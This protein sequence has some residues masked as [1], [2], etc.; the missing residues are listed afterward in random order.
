M[1]SFISRVSKLGVEVV[2]FDMDGTL[3][4]EY[5]FIS[6]AYK[7]VSF[8]I[9]E[10]YGLEQID[11]YK[12]L[13]DNWKKFGSSANIFQKTMQD[14]S[15]APTEKLIKDCIEKYRAANFKL[16]MTDEMVYLL[17]QLKKIGYKLFLIT[18]G[19]EN[20]Q[21]RKIKELGLERWFDDEN[22]AISGKYGK[23]YQKPNTYMKD[24]IRVLNEVNKVLYVGDR[25]ID[26]AFAKN[27][28]F[29]FINVESVFGPVSEKHSFY[30]MTIKR[31]FDVIL[32]LLSIIILLP[33]FI[34]VVLLELIC[35]GRPIVYT[36][37]RPGK[38]GKIFKMY[39]F[40]SMTNEIGDD[41]WLL[42]EDQRLTKFGRFIRKT[43]IDE[44]PELFNI[45]K[46]D[47]S[48]V[49]PRP[50]L[51]EYM[52][53]YSDRHKGRHLV[54]PGL[55]C[56]RIIPTESKTW[57]WGEQ[58]N[59]DLWYVKNVSFLVDVKMILAVIKEVFKARDIRTNDDRPPFL[60]DNLYDIRNKH[61]MDI[62]VRHE[63]IGR[64][65]NENSSDSTT[66]RR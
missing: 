53:Y 41:G 2:G 61:E 26:A 45:L 16:I 52:D 24:R 44:L 8:C 20:L 1:K 66:S 14:F 18:D 58:F 50:L 5:D 57:T 10:Y 27:C 55:A 40:R 64:L 63:S 33:I 30:S 37:Q 25:D 4:D 9:A 34:F 56:F 62:V 65:N 21:K 54:R 29:E 46:G 60:G 47:M 59:N 39:K 3:Y 7:P 42:P 13:C 35:H 6:Q 17:N 38:Y 19:D 32:S 51:V 49:G 22:I 15:V 12:S 31:L 28:N 23:E 11:V 36:T 43:S 48:V